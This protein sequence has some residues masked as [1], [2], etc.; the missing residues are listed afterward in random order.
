MTKLSEI[1]GIDFGRYVVGKMKLK[2]TTIKNI[3]TERITV[4]KIDSD[5]SSFSSDY[6]GSLEAKF[7]VSST[8]FYGDENGKYCNSDGEFYTTDQGFGVIGATDENG[9][10]TPSTNTPYIEITSPSASSKHKLDTAFDVTWNSANVVLVNIRFEGNTS[11]GY[12]YYDG[13]DATLGTLEVELPSDGADPFLAN[14]VITLTISATIGMTSDTVDINTIATVTMNTPVLTATVEGSITGTSNGEYI[15]VKWSVH[16][17]EEFHVFEEN[18]AVDEYGSWTA[19]GTIWA[20]GYKDFVAYDSTDSDGYARVDNVE[21]AISQVEFAQFAST[22]GDTYL[23]TSKIIDDDLYLQGWTNATSLFGETTGVTTGMLFVAKLN[24]Y[25]LEKI[26][27]KFYEV[28]FQNIGMNI[29]EDDTGDNLVFVAN[30]TLTTPKVY[31]IA[32][33]DGS[34]VGTPVNLDI[35]SSTRTIACNIQKSGTYFWVVGRKNVGGETATVWRLDH[36]LSNIT[37]TTLATPG[38]L[39]SFGCISSDG[40]SLVAN[41]FSA[42]QTVCIILSTGTPVYSSTN[43]IVNLNGHGKIVESNTR[44]M[45]Q[46]RK[47]ATPYTRYIRRTTDLTVINTTQYDQSRGD[48]VVLDQAG[49][50]RFISGKFY[51]LFYDSANAKFV[52]DRYA[53]SDTY[54][55]E[56]TIDI[57][58][59]TITAEGNVYVEG[60]SFIGINTTQGMLATVIKGKI[61]STSSTLGNYDIVLKVFNLPTP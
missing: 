38:A 55:L 32:K 54:A 19:T 46:T 36:D 34:T 28:N 3:G 47:Q 13:V 52:V 8:L 5:S 41:C 61:D 14:E 4:A 49:D 44:W 30:I 23:Y 27:A 43:Y 10:L 20:E 33:S 29:E 58:P 7:P 59:N 9:L 42:K 2:N 35:A 6:S 40:N 18:I 24:R 51:S 21:V 1:T 15:T 25:T 16:D 56:A 11:G 50:M 26:W 45:I 22:G 37:I 17:L 60:N 53:D 57:T 39:L 12:K 48:T 31:T